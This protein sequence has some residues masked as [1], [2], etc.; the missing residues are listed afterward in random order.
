[1]ESIELLLSGFAD[2]F[3]SPGVLLAAVLGCL[4]GT[5]VGALPGLGPSTAIAL[6][7][8][9]A[10][11]FA[12]ELTLV[13]MVAVYLG[14]EFGGRIAAILLNIPGDAGAIMT[15][16]DG[17]P[18]ARQGNA[19]VALSL[20]AI[21][22]FIGGT[23]GLLGLTLLTLPLASL[24]L[25][26]GPSEYFA[27]I[28]LALAITTV[29]VGESVL[30]GGIAILL[31]LAVA[32]VGTDLQSGVTRFTFGESYLLS[33]IDPI[34]PIIGVFGIGEVLW[35]IA[36]PG[37]SGGGRL[38]ITGRSY[39]NRQELS[40]IRW[41]IPRGSI[42]GFIAGVLPGSG[43]TLGSFL[44][45][46]IEQR[47]SKTPERFGEGA[48][49][50]VSAPE[51]GNNAAV[52][53]SIVPMFALGIPGSGTTAVLLA[54]LIS[55]GLQPG[56]GFFTE[57]SELAWLI[58]ASLFFSNLVL[59]CLN[60][61][62]VPLFAKILDVP[63]RFLFPTI[64]VIALLAGFTLTNSVFDAS[65]VL[66]FGVLGYAMRYVKL[67]PALLI[68][69]LVLGVLME[70]NFRQALQLN[71]GDLLAVLTTPLSLVFLGASVAL[72]AFDL[73]RGYRKRV[74]GEES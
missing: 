56:P 46:S 67:S 74:A 22:S 37:E 3:S 69:G 25:A 10:F 59:V 12:P 49:E 60:L 52:S 44:S 38:A 71:N 23:F 34:V 7:I 17:H 13:M 57:N 30:K 20:S 9:L 21:S 63:V 6:L 70:R 19:G 27:V 18:M 15:T 36:H 41:T 55:Y 1:M 2:L 35:N 47:V 61:P 31:G 53:G 16:V 8:P 4:L 39:P 54:Y 32:T 68:I 5:V 50:G 26:F 72:V 24:A 51:A 29:L 48:V 62:L 43:T 66:A 45:Y 73:W 11:V 42:L 64:M 33:G 65:L 40:R 14:A 28:V 58:I